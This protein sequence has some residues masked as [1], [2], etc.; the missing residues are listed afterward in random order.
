M[1]LLGGLKQVAIVRRKPVMIL[2]LY[3]WLSKCT[4]PSKCSPRQQ[5]RVLLSIDV[6]PNSC[7]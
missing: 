3:G 1:T 4:L 6:V 7:R 5:L 2:T